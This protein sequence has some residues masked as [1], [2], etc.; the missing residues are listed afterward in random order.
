MGGNRFGY[1][2]TAQVKLAGELV[3]SRG[4]PTFLRNPRTLI[5]TPIVLTRPHFHRFRVG[6]ATCMLA[7]KHSDYFPANAFASRF[8]FVESISDSTNTAVLPGSA[9]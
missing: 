2:N 4:I 1:V 9:A 3:A 5:L 8:S 7:A 6:E